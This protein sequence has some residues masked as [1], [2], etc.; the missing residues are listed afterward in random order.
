MAAR[1]TKLSEHLAVFHGPVNVGI[2]LDGRKA[3]LI[4]CADE[5]LADALREL[6]V[7][8]VEQ[9]LFTH[10][11]RDQACGAAALAARGARLAVPAAERDWFEKVDAYWADPARSHWRL[12]AN[13][14]AH[15][16]LA[17]PLRADAAFGDGHA[18][19]W[20]PAKIRVVTTP[21][22]TDGSVS[23]LVEADGKRVA[24]C[25]DAIYDE[26]RLW[27]VHSLQKG[28]GC[29]GDYHGFLGART[30]LVA[31][32]GRLK[33]AQPDALVPSHGCVM[34]D[35]PKAVDALVERLDRC[36]DRYVATSA[37]RHYFPQ[38]FTDFVGRPGHMPI[39]KGTPVPAC[40]R[41][42]STSWILVSRDKAAFVMDCADPGVVAEL[43]K[44]LAKGD[45]RS[46][47][48]LWIT[49]YHFDH[50]D[51]VPA[52][53][54]AFDC[55]CIVDRHLA[56]VLTD[57][58][59]WRLPCL[60]P[61]VCR[62]DCPTK[63]GDTWQWHEF[64]LTACHLPGQT[65]YHGGLLVEGEGVRMFFGGDSFTP[66]GIDD[67]CAQ[68]RNWLGK[69]VGYDHCLALIEKLQ[70]THVFNCHVNDAFD[71]TPEQLRLM[72][73]NLAERE[74][75]FGQLV[76]WDHANFGM[77]DS[78]VRCHPYEQQG[79]A[80]EG[81]A[82][83]VVVTNHAAEPRNAAVCAVLPRAW[84][85]LP[86][87]SGEGKGGG[88]GAWASAAIPAKSEASIPLTL[89]I[90]AGVP[91]GRYVVPVNVLFGAWELPQLVEAI[92]VL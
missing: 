20:G 13:L 12:Y 69:G 7:E 81:A 47:E 62:V 90:P 66:S 51:G 10:H 83:R 61:L 26:G 84:V 29:V 19:A 3:L 27:D 57:P 32:L 16:V 24:F 73:A 23:Y 70:P 58:P 76:P 85:S 28:F 45:I 68:N 46:V 18:F 87:P 79:R 6:G 33:A 74:T 31:S 43:K 72:R 21:G 5:G 82:F 78:W 34:A 22:H 63:D 38:L 86:P 80:G 42:F 11:H 60:S 17:E 40:L 71:F 88:A 49:H 14:R 77:D 4:D 36:Y 15:L 89:R 56:E 59:A 2:V 1:V 48:G 25:G 55:P 30:Q 67:Y 9:V 41:H 50:M 54:R 39:R 91:P 37:L 8:T 92:V 65:L 53:Q 75:L 64:K 52:F 35:P 44:M